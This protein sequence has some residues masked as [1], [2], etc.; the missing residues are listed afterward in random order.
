MIAIVIIIA[1]INNSYCYSYKSLYGIITPNPQEM[2]VKPPETHVAH[3][4]IL[5]F[6][7]RPFQK[8]PPKARSHGSLSSYQKW[9]RLRERNLP[10]KQR[11]SFECCSL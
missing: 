7:P 4:V 1:I 9:R 2:P 5:P 10:P 8:S 3:P 11:P 6:S